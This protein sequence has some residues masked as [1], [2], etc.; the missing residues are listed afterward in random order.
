MGEAS[1]NTNSGPVLQPGVFN[2]WGG[3]N[4]TNPI[5]NSGTQNGT[6]PGITQ[7][8]ASNGLDTAQILEALGIQ[9][10]STDNAMGPVWGQVADYAL[11]QIFGNRP[12]GIFAPPPNPYANQLAQGSLQRLGQYNTGNA[13]LQENL[14]GLMQNQ[15][16]AL[17]GGQDQAERIALGQA[18]T[19]AD[20]AFNRG[21]SNLALNFAQRNLNGGL[22]V[23]AQ[24][25]LEAQRATTM[26]NA[27]NNAAQQRIARNDANRRYMLQFLSSQL[28]QNNNLRLQDQQLLLNQGNWEAQRL[29]KGQGGLGELLAYQFRPCVSLRRFGDS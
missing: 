23:G 18:Q 5:W 21:R 22:K 27:Y 24:A 19:G 25:N 13:Q 28:A 4:T 7:N 10:P 2:E 1:G 15:L 9:A 29:A 26:A 17:N 6:T 16:N 14:N 11:G 12:S 20:K 3:P 8:A